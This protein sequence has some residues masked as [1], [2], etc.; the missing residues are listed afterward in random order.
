MPKT[1]V[2]IAAAAIVVAAGYAGYTALK[3]PFWQ[4]GAPLR[5]GSTPVDLLADL[6]TGNLTEGWKERRFFRVTPTDYRMTTEDDAPALR[7]T[8]NHSASILARDTDIAIDDLPILSWQWKVTQPIQSTLDEDTHEG[9]DHPLRYYLRFV[10]DAG[11]EKSTEIIWSNK[12]YAAG[13]FKII[14]DFYHLVANGLDANVGTWHDQTVDLRK[15]YADIGG[16]GDARLDVI[17]FF[18]D[19]DNTGANSDGYFRNIRLSPAP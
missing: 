7:C 11:E 12:K 15:L 13:D 14:G 5:A 16:I 2:K 3:P 17:G 4:T 18:C 8:T 10:N 19:S 9:D 6:D 1:V